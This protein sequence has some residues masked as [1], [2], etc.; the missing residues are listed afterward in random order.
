MVCQN[1]PIKN[2]MYTL[3]YICRAQREQKT[4]QYYKHTRTHTYVNM[5]A[6]RLL[7]NL[8]RVTSHTH[9]HTHT[10]TI[11]FDT[12]IWYYTKIHTHTIT[13]M[14][15]CAHIPRS[16]T[17]SGWLPSH[18]PDRNN[19]HIQTHKYPHSYNNIHAYIPRTL[20]SWLPSGREGIYLNAG[21]KRAGSAWK[22]HGKSSFSYAFGSTL[23]KKTCAC[24][25]MW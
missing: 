23:P 15:I 8:E 24:M 4:W 22:G 19:I 3:A 2:N 6:F 9:K 18:L 21:P 20:S 1:R 16:S 25:Y 17:L 7:P 12:Y 11:Y 14:L 10:N 13:C 5:Q